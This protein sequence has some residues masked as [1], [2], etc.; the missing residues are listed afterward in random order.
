MDNF[1]NNFRLCR[2][3]YAENKLLHGVARTHGQCVPEGVIQKEV[4]SK[5]KQDN[6]RGEL[7]VA[8][9]KGD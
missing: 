3:T 9:R 7:K 5:K 8:V 4:K 2:A 1:Y 6:S